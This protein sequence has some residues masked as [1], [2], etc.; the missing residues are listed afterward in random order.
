M[1]YIS[2]A[3]HIHGKTDV[4][5]NYAVVQHGHISQEGLYVNGMVFSVAL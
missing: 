2:K 1:E 4:D 3:L 5:K